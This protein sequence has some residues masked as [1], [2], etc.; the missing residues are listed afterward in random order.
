MITTMFLSELAPL[1][2][3]PEP[4]FATNS[5]SVGPIPSAPCR[6]TVTWFPAS[7]VRYNLLSK[8]H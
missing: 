8:N 2:F 6:V 1:Y 5:V 7:V 3:P 4:N